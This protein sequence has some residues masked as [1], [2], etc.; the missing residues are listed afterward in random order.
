M[1]DI[2]PAAVNLSGMTSIALGRNKRACLCMGVLVVGLLGISLR[3][4]KF[5]MGREYLNFFGD[6]VGMG[7]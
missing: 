3:R 5:E 6:L 4:P 7:F 2:C 1:R